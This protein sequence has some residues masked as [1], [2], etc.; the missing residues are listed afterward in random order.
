M[1][2]LRTAS[3]RHLRPR[4]HRPRS[5]SGPASPRPRAGRQHA[6]AKPLEQ[7]V[8]D[9]V[10]AP[11]GRTGVSARITF[12]NGC[13]P[14]ARCPGRGSPLT[15]GA[16]GRLWLA[17]T[18]ALRLELQSETGDAQIVVRRERSPSTTRPPTPSTGRAA[19]RR[20]SAKARREPATLADVRGPR[21]AR[22]GVDPVRRAADAPPASRPTRCASRRR[23]TA[24]C[25]ARPSWRG[26]PPAACR[27]ARPS[28]PR[29]RTT[30]C[31]SS[32]PTDDR[33]R[34][35]RRRRR[36]RPTAGRR[37]GRRSSTRPPGTTPQGTPTRVRGV[38]AV[39][40]GIGF[41][42]AA[43]AELA[44]L[45]RTRGP[46]RATWRR[47]GARSASTARASARSRAPA[48]GGADAGRRPRR[49]AAAGDQIDGATGSELA[50][51][52]GTIVTFE[53]DGVAYTVLGSVPPVAAQNAARGL[54]ERPRRSRR[55]GLVKRYGDV[56]AVDQVDLTV[57]AGDVY[58]YLGPNGAG[59]T[60]SLRMLLGLIRPDE[61][62]ARL[63]G[64]DPRAGRGARARRRRRLRRGAALLPVHERPPQ[65]RAG[66]RARRR[67]RG[68]AHRRRAG[69]PST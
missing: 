32:T 45:P 28:T 27:C 59:K 41:N 4:R 17:A 60:T 43:P 49:A 6:R 1:R 54:D 48:R 58:G 31:S 40:S 47:A 11:D 34:Q 44:G 23:T 15:A 69:R 7:A 10:D 35:G 2:R 18:A 16:D 22:P 50:T 62:T 25:S 5:P 64:R 52:L 68:R 33:L 12:T 51:A 24:G 36:R 66:G 61:G 29:A 37:Q 20:A 3:T 13:S 46:A 53:R 39:P 14:R 9:A 42:V 8:H 63:F 38:D 65:P 55:A 30:R 56:T 57:G 19:R 21:P 26:T 67:R